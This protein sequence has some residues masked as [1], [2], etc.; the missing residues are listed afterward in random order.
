MPLLPPRPFPLSLSP[1]LFGW[2]LYGEFNALTQEWTDGIASTFIRQAVSLTTDSD[3]F[4]WVIFDGPVDAIWIENMNTVLDDN[5]TLCLANGERIKLNKKMHMVFEVE[6]LSVASPATVSRVGIVYLTP[7]NLGWR[8]YVISWVAREC[9]PAEGLEGGARMTPQLAEHVMKLFETTIDGSLDWIRGIIGS[10][11][12]VPTVNSQLIESCCAMFISLLPSAKLNLD[13]AAFGDSS[14]VLS[15]IFFFCVIWSV[16]ASID[17]AHWAAFDELLREQMAG[18]GVIFPGGGDV[19]DYFVDL[20]AKDFKAWKEVV[21]D[22]VYDPKKSFFSMLVPTVDT[23]RYAFIFEKS[24]EVARSV[25]F[26]GHSGVGKSVVIA[27]MMTRMVDNGSSNGTAWARM[28]LSF[29][30]QT[31][32]KRTQETIES[33]LDKRKKTLLG[34][35]PGKKLI[36]FVDDVN[37]PALETYGASPPVELLRQFL[38]YKGFYDRAKI[39][40]KSLADVVE[41]SA[42]GPPGG[43]KNPLTPRYVRHHTVVAVTQPSG[44]AM[45]RI[46]QSIVDGALA[47]NGQA[48]IIALGKP[49]VVSSVDTYFQVLQDLKPIPAKSHYTFN[50]R[51]VSKIV[52]G[53]LMMKPQA[54]PNKE[55]LAKLWAHESLRVFCDRLIDDEDRKYFMDMI[56]DALKVQFKMGWSYEDLFDSEQKLVFGDYTKMGTPRDD[57][58][59]EEV[60]DTTKLP[61]LFADYLDEYNA[62]NKEM[63]LVFFWDACDHVNR[64]ARVLRQPRGNAML[65]GV[66][67]S[68]KQSLTRF[69]AFMSEM[70]CFQIELTKG[71]GINEFREDLKKCFFTAGIEKTEDGKIGVPIVFL[72]ADTQVVDESF[73]EDINNILNSGE[74]PNLFAE[75]EWSKI[76]NGVR[77]VAKELGIPETKDNLK[78]LFVDMTREN[79]HIVLAMSPVGS[80]FRVRCRMFPSLINCCTIDWY[81]RWPVEALRSVAKQFLEPLDFGDDP[82]VRATVLGGLIEMSSLIHTSVIDASDDFFREL[83][84]KFYVTPK[85]FLELISLYLDMLGGKRDDMMTGIK[86]LEVGVKKIN[87]TN[88]LVDGMQAELTELQPVLVIKSK[89]AEE[90]IIQVNKD[91]ALAS[92]K[93]AKVAQDEAAVKKIADEVQIIADDAKRDLDAAMPALHGALKAL[94]SLSKGD[95][96]E[97]KNFKTPPSLVQMVMEGVCILLGA[98]PDW[99][100]AKKVLGDTQFL[101]RLINYDKDNIPPKVIKQIIKYYD[102]P[103]FTPEAVE[104]QSVAAKSLCQWVRA[105]KVYD[106][107]AKVVEPKKQLLAESMAKLQDEQGRLQK[108]QDELAAVIAKVDELQATCDATVAEKQRLQDMAD[109]TSKRLVR[110]GKLTSGLADEAVRWRDTVATLHEEYIALTGDVFISAA[111]IAYNGPFTAGYRKT[112]CEGWVEQCAER[113]IPATQGF[114]LIK[115]MGDPVIIREWQL[116]GLPVDDYSTEN[117]IL[118][119]KGK[120]WPLAIDPQAQANRWIRN[121]EASNGIKVSKGNDAAILRTLENAIR[122]GSPVMLEDVT[123]ELDPSLEPV[124]QKQIYKQGGRSLIRIGDSDVDYNPDFKCA[125]DSDPNPVPLS[126]L[127]SP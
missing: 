100:S 18:S 15:S 44:D 61:Q 91:Q 116:Q 17:E 42:C 127:A 118:A 126:F 29:S 111:F 48:D 5:M 98:K 82:E 119:T 85:S 102:D 101:N 20:P 112:T 88:A 121:L 16:G 122:M 65:V 1:H 109:T 107:V 74:V 8:P 34:P 21:P 71:Y 67:G 7:L 30:A 4:Q 27:D 12:L 37:M 49:I 51:D 63:R 6:D 56:I 114:S 25:L 58:K 92:E 55:C 26:T 68:G 113:S 60:A 47:L 81:D 117:G 52:Q 93:K 57:R 73:I 95:I 39:F 120:R 50:L 75:D 45:K 35:P 103:Q 23:V 2:Q 78:Q 54:I 24:M 105:M 59:Y 108:I 9:W 124:L 94:D 87:E 96:V 22:F 64:L 53:V 36:M 97:I 32:A 46:F 79:L 104:R 90:M 89:E 31:N 13:A 33:K 38:D 99:D 115:V 43:G 40:F 70:K 110:A 77:P 28:D 10:R 41:A 123:E 69:A 83:K 106:E 11:E 66:G 80:A 84:R 125:R 14:K 3:D 86:R 62:E 76:T 19:H 72:F